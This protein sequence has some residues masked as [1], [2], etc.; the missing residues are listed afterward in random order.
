MKRLMMIPQAYKVGL[1]GS[2]FPL[3]GAGDFT[4]VRNGTKTRI[5]AQ[6]VISSVGANIPAFNYIGGCPELSIE[7]QA[8]QLY[9]HTAVMATQTKTVTAVAHTVSFYGTGRIDFSG[10]FTGSLIGT[11]ENNRVSLTFTPTAGGLVSTVVGS[12]LLA[13]LETGVIATSYIPNTTTGVITRIADN[14]FNN[15]TVAA[16]QPC[17]ILE[18]NDAFVVPRF[19]TNEINLNQISTRRFEVYDSLTDS[20]IASLGATRRQCVWASRLIADGTFSISVSGTGVVHWGDGTTSNYN[21][22]KITLTRVY[23][24]FNGIIYVMGTLTYISCDINNLRHNLASLPAGLTV[25]QNFG[26]NTTFGNIASLPAGL[27]FYDNRGQ[28]TVDRYDAG[29]A[30]A[31]NMRQFVS[32]PQTGIGLTTVMVDALLVDLANVPSWV[33]ERLI[34]LRGGNAPRSAASDGAVTNLQ[35]RGVTVLTN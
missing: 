14:I 32:I 10:A 27:T 20:E 8:T 3:S 21:G 22:S 2:Q 9:E 18:N 5:N 15:A 19:P 1:L 26:Q 17:T 28:N 11:G 25:Y 24:M 30:W 34:D 7:G 31:N 6:G 12:V 13:Q 29:R 16:L 23:S 33:H 35:G 4:V